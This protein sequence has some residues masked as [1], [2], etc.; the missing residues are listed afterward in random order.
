MQQHANILLGRENILP[1]G[2]NYLQSL[3]PT[4][5][6]EGGKPFSGSKMPSLIYHQ[7]NPWVQSYDASVKM[8]IFSDWIVW[9]VK[10]ANTQIV[11]I[12]HFTIKMALK[13]LTLASNIHLTT[14]IP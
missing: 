4:E 1:W 3:I 10:Q 9:M 8:N 2:N 12:S 13:W 11:W 14:E 5:P 7:K 6:F